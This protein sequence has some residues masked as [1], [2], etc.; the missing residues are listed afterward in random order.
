MAHRSTSEGWPALEYAHWQPT[1][2]ALHLWTQIVGKARLAQT[3]WIN[4]SWHAT[5]Y[6]TARRLTT[7]T[8]P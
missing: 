3:P 8:I 1:C 2:A 6:L 4:H 7:S 5:F